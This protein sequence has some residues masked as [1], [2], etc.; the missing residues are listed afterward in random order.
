MKK[1]KLLLHKRILAAV[2][3]G[4]M[5][6]LPNWGYALPQ[7]GTVVAG[8]GNI[9]DP[10]NITG[11]GNMAIEWNSFNIGK[12]ETVTFSGMQAVLNY[13]TGNTKSEILGNITGEKVHVFLVNPNGILFGAEAKVNVGQLT[14]S[15]RTIEDR[16]SFDGSAFSTLSVEAA[17]KVRGDIINLG[18]LTANKIVLEGDN[19]SLL[20]AATLNTKN[21]DNSNITLRANNKVTVGYEVTDK[22]TI[23][24]GDGVSGGHEVSDYKKGGGTKGSTVLSG[25]KLERLNKYDNT[26]INITDAMLVHN[27]YELQAIANNTFVGS[28]CYTY[29]QGDYM[30]AND[31]NASDTVN[32]NSGKGFASIGNISDWPNG[33]KGGFTGSLDGMECKIM[34]LNIKRTDTSYYNGCYVG[35]FTILREGASVKNIR[36]TDYETTDTNGITTIVKSN[37]EGTQQVGGI[38]GINYGTIS[39][40]TNEAN[41][42]AGSLG[43]I[44]G[45]VGVNYGKLD[46][47]INKGTITSTG[48]NLGG[49]AGGN[50]GGTINNARNE[51]AIEA[52][53]SNVGGIV[54][55]NSA[56]GT[57]S[58][59]VNSGKITGS[60]VS[61]VG[62]I[63]G[64][65][66][67]GIDRGGIID[68]CT[69][70]KE[71][72]INITGGSNIGGIAGRNDFGSNGTSGRDWYSITNS[73]NYAAVS[74]KDYV[75]GIVGHNKDWIEKNQNF[76]AI[77]GTGSYVG[78]I[79]GANSENPAIIENCTNSGVITGINYVGGIAGYNGYNDL[80]YAA[81]ITNSHNTDS[82]SVTGNSYV[83]GIV[84]YNGYTASKGGAIIEKS[85]NSGVVKATGYTTSSGKNYSYVGGIAGYNYKGEI[86]DVTNNGNVVGSY[87][88]VGGVVGYNWGDITK[89]VNKGTVEGASYYVGGIAGYNYGK[90]TNANNENSIKGVYYVGGISGHNGVTLT[91]VHNGN[92]GTVTGNG[93]VGGISGYNSGTIGDA[94]K[95]TSVTNSGAI[96][97]KGFTSSGKSN[98]YV[99]GITGYNAGDI[100]QT[101]NKGTVTGAGNYSGGV[102]GYNNKNISDS[103][104]TGDVDV[105]GNNQQVGGISG[106]NSKSGNIK[107]VYNSGKISGVF[108]AGGIVGNHSGGGSITNAYNIGKIVGTIGYIGDI[109]GYGSGTVTNAYYASFDGDA[110]AGYLKYDGDGTLLS[111]E[112]FGQAFENGLRDEDKDSWKFYN[113]NTAPLLKG[114]LK[115]ITVNGDTISGVDA[116]YNGSE[117]IAGLGGLADGILVGAKKEIGTY[118]LEDLLYSGQDGYDITILNDGIKF[119]IR[120]VPPD[121]PQQPSQPAVPQEGIYQNALVNIAITERENRPEQQNIRQRIIDSPIK[122]GEE[123]AKVRIEGDG[124]KF[125]KEQ[126]RVKVDDD[127]IKIEEEA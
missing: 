87:Y 85:T 86:T 20:N 2:L 82:G 18:E 44:G 16:K 34:G 113:G 126:I 15:T 51:A 26:E 48:S 79:V 74:G 8:N 63:V 28:D 45:I 75:G 50:N 61:N 64:Y 7:G 55:S 21:N 13:V 122:L 69:N 77:T 11:S 91:D 42:T 104:N 96:E 40:V 24:V 46:N 39:N 116:V 58:N 60:N 53:A 114:F 68:S 80:D 72:V 120:E 105:T 6:L 95:K 89:G 78:G 112:E 108:Y 111:L 102:V 73:N 93:Y 47:V 100:I 92:A 109:I 70:T 23:N 94:D 84:G 27:V 123:Q 10:S 37:I 97:A 32:W 54:G 118:T 88:A 3:S 106:S 29:V 30:L 81:K 43:E 103:Y 71:A 83:G 1:T 98:A 124:I 115:K 35:L 33:P 90:I 125:E 101:A 19:I 17:K 38:A 66:G 65:N 25:V 14:A 22:T 41:I 117:Q 119:T 4:G 67:S 49:I 62:G 12:N 121:E 59:S 56:M 99:G 52:K 127:G 31:I 5:L 57:I 110:I 107:N 9:S 76:G 36:L